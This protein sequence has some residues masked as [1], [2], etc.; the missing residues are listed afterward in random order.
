MDIDPDESCQV[1][2]ND[3]EVMGTVCA[4]EIPKLDLNKTEQFDDQSSS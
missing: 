4:P 3:Q 1:I 2:I